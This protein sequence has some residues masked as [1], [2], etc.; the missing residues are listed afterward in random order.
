MEVAGDPPGKDHCQLAILP[1][2]GFEISLK[3]AITGEHPLS[4]CIKFAMGGLYTST[5]W[6][7]VSMHPVKEVT[8]NV[9]VCVPAVG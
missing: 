5:C 3:P 9:T 2:T 1:S 7:M 4:G 6:V 8:I